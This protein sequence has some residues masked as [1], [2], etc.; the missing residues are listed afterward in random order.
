MQSSSPVF[1]LSDAF[2]TDYASVAPVAA[3]IAGLPG[4]TS[5]WDDYSPDGATAVL[6]L[7]TDYRRR[8]SAL[9]PE[10]SSREGLA[11]QVLA[12]F[13]DER[14]AFFESC[15]NL[16]DL[17]NIESPAQHVRTVFDVMDTRAVEDWEA[18]AQRLSALEGAY[19]NYRSALSLGLSRG[20]SAS[21]RQVAAVIEQMEVHASAESSY[22]DLLR[23]FDEAKLN[24]GSLRAALER[25]VATAK[26][27]ASEF[28][29]YLR[30]YEPRATARDAVLEERYARSV[31]RFLGTDLDLEATYRWGFE[32]IRAIGAEMEK[33]ARQVEP[34]RAA[35][36]HLVQ[37]VIFALQSDVSRQIFDREVFLAEV[38]ARQ[39]Q[40][41]N[42]LS[43]THFDIPEK[44]RRV[45]V[46]LG[47]KGGPIGAY[48]VPP[49][50]DFSRP[51]TIYY[52]PAEGA[53]Y[54]L[55]SEITTAYH[56]GFPGHHLQCGLQVHFAESLS[57]FHRLFVVSSGYAEGW[58]LYAESLMAELGYYERPE[59]LLGMHM[60][61]MFRACRVV[62]DIGA[63][64]ELKIPSDFDFH[65]GET[66]SWAL[67]AELL[68]TK[69]LMPSSFAESEATRYLGWPAQ[70]I[71][72]KV[73]ERTILELRDEL[74]SHKDFTLRAFHEAVLSTGSVGLDVLKGHVR[75]R[76]ARG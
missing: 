55:F 35:S 75:R 57:R 11:H 69:A 2:T 60:A 64:L 6:K 50:E 1:A 53:P 65:P 7:C 14:I 56:E 8:L 41:L 9:T 45:D 61:K 40:A 59:Y 66:W 20:L 46:K 48:Y 21:K 23:Q 13:L 5:A 38:R 32:E 3:S 71:S 52:S 74:R 73:G 51:G 30:E 22:A 17:N 27:C 16:I 70:A 39:E 26:R 63:H 36:K 76:F 25:G 29:A 42:D 33:T 19:A 31:R 44:I 49:N 68:Q 10:P 72:Y 28:A 58:A 37:E 24:A 47:P 67:V 43:G 12:D 4:R 18:I 15:D 62:A 34:Q 54:V